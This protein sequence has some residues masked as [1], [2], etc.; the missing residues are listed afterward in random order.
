MF[1][2]SFFCTSH[3]GPLP[4]ALDTKYQITI[5]RAQKLSFSP[6]KRKC[7]WNMDI[8]SEN[9]FFRTAK[10]WST[11]LKNHVMAFIFNFDATFKTE[12][13]VEKWI[14]TRPLMYKLNFTSF[15]LTRISCPLLL[16]FGTNRKIFTTACSFLIGLQAAFQQHIVQS[17]V[18]CSSWTKPV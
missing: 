3:N 12:K 14:R 7:S 2:L 13:L 6:S 17:K 10:L 18:F 16:V 15:I 4:S 5:K 8:T 9:L 11:K 1:G